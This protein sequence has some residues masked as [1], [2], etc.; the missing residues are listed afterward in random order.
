MTSLYISVLNRYIK[1]AKIEDP[2]QIVRL[3]KIYFIK[4]QKANVKINKKK[5]VFLN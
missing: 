5:T 2:L 1:E 3:M 4:D